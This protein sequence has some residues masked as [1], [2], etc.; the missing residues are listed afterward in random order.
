MKQYTAQREEIGALIARVL[1]EEKENTAA[2]FNL[3][4]AK[5]KRS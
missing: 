1:R 3:V 2:D 5:T 4:L